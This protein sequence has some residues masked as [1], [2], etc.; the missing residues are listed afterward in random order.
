MVI[1]G[2]GRWFGLLGLLAIVG[3]CGDDGEPTTSFGTSATTTTTTGGTTTSAGTTTGEE[4]SGTSGGGS[5]TS[6]STGEPV[7]VC[8]DGEV[9]VSGE[10]C[11]EGDANA[12]D[13]AC[14]SQCK[15]AVCG[16]SLVQ[17]GV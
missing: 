7:G 3:G 15:A 8:G 2:F 9:N 17:A 10:E 1:S 13:G 12:D 5:G 11:D 14:T 16:D 4:T 6:G